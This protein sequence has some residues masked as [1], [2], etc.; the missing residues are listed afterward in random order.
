[1]SLFG[2]IKNSISWGKVLIV[3]NGLRIEIQPSSTDKNP[4]LNSEHNKRDI[5]SSSCL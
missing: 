1:M 4:K 2:K 5:F 3:F